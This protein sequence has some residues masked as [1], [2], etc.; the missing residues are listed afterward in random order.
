MAK[1]KLKPDFFVPRTQRKEP[2]KV[3]SRGGLASNYLYV[4]RN[5]CY[6][7]VYPLNSETHQAK[8]SG[9][10]KSQMIIYLDKNKNPISRQILDAGIPTHKLMKTLDDL[11]E[12]KTI[13]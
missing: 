3:P 7:F 5:T 11:L 9:Q 1:Y 8:Y 6:L 13:H 12:T 2:L 4:S 10:T